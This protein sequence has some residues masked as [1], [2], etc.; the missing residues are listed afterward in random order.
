[1]TD[2]ELSNLSSLLNNLIFT[3]NNRQMVD[4]ELLGKV[5]SI[6]TRDSYHLISPF[7]ELNQ[8]DGSKDYE[9]ICPFCGGSNF[10]LAPKYGLYH[11]F[12]CKS[13]GDPLALLVAVSK[14]S[15]EDVVNELAQ[16]YE[17]T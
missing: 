9:G 1:M 16:K 11:C 15:L 13:S 3:A 8:P 4:Q 14:R 17:I 10:K 6:A 5:L 12:D 7:I 2:Q